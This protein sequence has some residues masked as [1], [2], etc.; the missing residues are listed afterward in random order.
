M[1]KFLTVIIV[2]LFICQAGCAKENKPAQVVVP[3]EVG[4]NYQVSIVE[5]KTTK[6]EVID[7]LGLPDSMGAYLSYTFRKKDTCKLTLTQK[8]GT[9]LNLVLGKQPGNKYDA[10]NLFLNKDGTINSVHLL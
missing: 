5:D 6:Q 9:V 3:V 8:D 1:K 2:A 10:M 7:A 4:Q